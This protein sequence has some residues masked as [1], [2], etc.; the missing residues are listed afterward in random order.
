ME[1]P[2]AA[3][4]H[5]DLQATLNIILKN[6]VEALGGSAGVVATWDATERR[7]IPSATFGL[8]AKSLEQLR[9][10]LDEAIPDLAWS[11]E[12]F[13][14]LSELRLSSSLPHSDKGVPQNP[15]IVLPLQIGEK[16]VGLIYV[17]RPLKGLP[18]SRMDQPI[19]AAFAEQAAIAVHNARL[20]HLLAQEKQAIE[21]ILENSAEGIMSIDGQRRI[22]GFNTA[23]E[24]LTGWQ[25]KEVLGKY[26]FKI[27]NLR[28]WEGNALCARQCPMLTR[29]DNAGST[30]EQQG[31]IKT[32]DG[33]DID[34]AMV[35]SITRSPKGQPVS[36]VINVRD[37]TKFREVESLRSSFLSMLGHEL[38]TPL[39]IIKG[40]TSTL[41]RQDGKW[42]EET[43]RQGLQIIE[44]EC[45]RLSK[46]MNSLLLASRIESGALVL[47]REPVLVQ[48]LVK[49]VVRKLQPMTKI[50]TF[51]M[52]LDSHLPEVLA[53]PEQIEQVLTNLIDNAI[54]YS[55]DGGKITISGSVRN[56][57][58]EITVAD[59]GIG[60]PLREID[61]IFQ[62]FHRVD[63][64]LVQKVRGAGLGLYIC[65]SIIEAHGGKISVVS[66]LGKGSRFAFT[67]PLP[68][69]TEQNGGSTEHGYR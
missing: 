47:R 3:L 60:I 25:R 13:A 15:V 53:D 39:S 11:K 59:Q 40:Y 52:N 2:R 6:A 17:L 43:L 21:S 16:S 45:D 35:Y 54:K 14:L 22:V 56:K 7:F 12:S 20:A 28:D 4:E 63:N 10:F 38:Q 50:H 8:D 9:P 19:L 26:C 31:K 58:L 36:S 24:R 64:K 67:I 1:I 66:E 18:F 42:N 27:L 46:L 37:I 48:H 33:V 41:S 51:E 44:E 55:P 32:R 57:H 68:A 61:H 69:T 23:M 34:I 65:K 49:K 62:R 5:F 29:Q 30:V